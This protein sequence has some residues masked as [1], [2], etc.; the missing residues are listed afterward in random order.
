MDIILNLYETLK[1]AKTFLRNLLLSE[2]LNKP[3][4]CIITDGV[5]R[6][7]LDIG[8]E[9]GVPV[10]YFRTISSCSFWSYFCMDKLV[11]AAE[12]PFEG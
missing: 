4:T 8:E 11:E 5:M 7:T 12:C 10:I 1:T 9:I 6:F 3:V 2:G